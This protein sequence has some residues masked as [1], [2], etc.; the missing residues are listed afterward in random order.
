M[1]FK[2]KR[3]VKT[4]ISIVYYRT[5]DICT[6]NDNITVKYELLIL[7]KSKI[8]K[9]HVDNPNLSKRQIK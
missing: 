7:Q 2:C 6:R 1:Q 4:K 3:K 9:L 5:K 8:T